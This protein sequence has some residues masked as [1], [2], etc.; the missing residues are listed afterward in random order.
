MIIRPEMEEEAA[1]ALVSRFGELVQTG[2]GQAGEVEKW[3]RRR[4]AYELEG[5]RDGL[6]FFL[7]FE[8]GPTVPSEL[9]RQAK[10]TEEILRHQI[11]R[12][13]EE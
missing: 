4:L 3:G 9:D 6:Y 2:G 1:L 11:V 10:L 13:D 5:Q 8:A 12:L 7:P